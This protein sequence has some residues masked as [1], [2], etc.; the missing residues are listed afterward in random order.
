MPLRR[1]NTWPN[2]R[3]LKQLL[4]FIMKA[5]LP[6]RSKQPFLLQR[7]RLKPPLQLSRI[8]RLQILRPPPAR[9][10]SLLNLRIIDKYVK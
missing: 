5:P 2:R 10:R 4:P 3:N 7:H 9:H 6:L 8:P 1:R